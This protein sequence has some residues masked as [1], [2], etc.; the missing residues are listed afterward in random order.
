MQ[1]PPVPFKVPYCKSL[2]LFEGQPWKKKLDSR[3]C[4]EN[5][6]ASSS[7]WGKGEQPHSC[8][9][10]R[11]IPSFWSR[12]VKSCVPNFL[13]QS[14]S[15]DAYTPNHLLVT[16]PQGFVMHFL[17]CCDA[18]RTPVN[19]MLKQDWLSEWGR[20]DRLGRVQVEDVKIGAIQ[21]F[22]IFPKT[23]QITLVFLTRR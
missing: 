9:Y 16:I 6:F 11:I 15:S 22:A 4:R 7:G 19:V 2:I 21:Q 10:L 1:Q 8:V 3:F 23:S 5:K 13:S 14:S 20:N 12:R 18:G 17:K